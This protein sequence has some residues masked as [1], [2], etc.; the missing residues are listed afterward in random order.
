MS[1]DVERDFKRLQQ[2]FRLNVGTLSQRHIRPMSFHDPWF[3][4]LDSSVLEDCAIIAGY[5]TAVC[6]GELSPVGTARR[7]E[8]PLGTATLD[9]C[10]NNFRSEDF[11][12]G[13]VDRLSISL[14]TWRQG[15]GA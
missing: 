10:D 15:L 9:S 12:G 14:V 7:W 13:D 1:V 2:A 4:R 6:A 5:C 8:P 11:A 3:G